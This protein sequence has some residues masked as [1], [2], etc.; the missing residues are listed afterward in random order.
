MARRNKLLKFTELL[1]FPHVFENF[2][3]EDEYLTNGPGI[4][5]DMRGQWAAYFEND[6]P[7]TLELACG[8]GEYSLALAERYPNRNFIGIDIKGARIWKGATIAMEKGLKNVAFLRSKIEFCTNFF[9]SDEI[10]EIWITF[11]DPF[12][13]KSKFNRRLTSPNYLKSYKHYLKEGG[14]IHLKT[15]SPVMYEHTIEVLKDL[16]FPIYIDDPDIYGKPSLS[17]EDLDINTYYELKNISNSETIKYVQFGL[18][19]FKD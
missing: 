12:L 11:P 18:G 7:I 13:K 10:S 6:N 19:E 4:E 16:Q 9:Q 2:K 14:H 17:Q 3:P 8:R 1:T 15:D 5:K